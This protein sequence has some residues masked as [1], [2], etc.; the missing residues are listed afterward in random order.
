MSRGV[1]VAAGLG[2]QWRVAF[3]LLPDG[4]RRTVY[5]VQ[6]AEDYPPPIDAPLAES[7]YPFARGLES[8]P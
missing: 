4:T 2:P 5:Y 1:E 6:A 8:V 3:E 7:E